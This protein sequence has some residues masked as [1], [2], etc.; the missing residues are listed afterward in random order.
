MNNLKYLFKKYFIVLL[1]AIIVN[2]PICLMGTIRTNKTITLKGDTTI[3]NE[4]IEI[5][6]KNHAVGSFSSIFVVSFDHSTILQNLICE[7]DFQV[8]V[9]D[10]YEG[11]LHFSDEELTQMGRIQYQSS[12][13]NSIILAYQEASK[14]NES[15]K[16]DYLFDSFV[17]SYYS[18]NSDLRIEDEIIGINGIY[19][20]E[21][22]ELFKDTFNN[23][24]QG[25]VLNV[26]RK[27]TEIDILLNEKNYLNYSGYSF[28]NIDINNTFPKYK[29]NYTNVGGP[30]GGL[31]QTLSNYNALVE[32]DITK[33]YKVAG[34]GTININGEVGP[35]GGIIQKIY[36]AYDDN[37]DIFL[38]PSENYEEALIAYNK[39]PKDNK[40][41]LYS[42]STFEEALEVL[43]NA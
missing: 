9:E 24:Q 10:I 13:N 5:E 17:V 28:Y 18:E 31:L 41:R 11:Y 26:L 33:G 37:V 1:V 40:M 35:I 21:N 34:T 16:I 30:S 39:L 42:I 19:A 36:T 38:C 2:L 7:Y 20:G 43:K 6:N 14:T 23:Q 8:E 12:L 15:I 4:V 3:V 25:D 32:E 29:I 22:F 27:G